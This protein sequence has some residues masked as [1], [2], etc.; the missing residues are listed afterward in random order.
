MH[1]INKRFYFSFILITSLLL[2]FE[3]IV[4]FMILPKQL[5]KYAPDQLPYLIIIP[6]ISILLCYL[7][8]VYKIGKNLPSII[9]T[10]R[11]NKSKILLISQLIPMTSIPIFNA[12]Y[13]WQFS[14][15]CNNYIEENK[16]NINRISENLFKK[17]IYF[18]IPFIIFF[19]I[20]FIILFIFIFISTYQLVNFSNELLSKNKE[21]INNE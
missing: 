9:N 19:P 13:M 21:N 17:F 7:T 15:D 10:I 14:K 4:F 6:A 8:L 16:L 12:Y 20:Y 5:Y 11:S 1:Y 18:S 3:I 2:I